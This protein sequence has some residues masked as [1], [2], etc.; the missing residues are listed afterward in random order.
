MM[1]LIKKYWQYVV[2]AVIILGLVQQVNALKQEVRTSV[3][4]VISEDLAKLEASQKDRTDKL[5]DKIDRQYK[6]FNESLQLIDRTLVRITTAKPPT[7]IAGPPGP[8]GPPGMPGGTPAPILVPQP[9]IPGPEV[10]AARTAASERIVV[11]LVVGSLRNCL[12]P[13]LPQ[14]SIELLRQ[15]NG[16][17]LSSTPCVLSIHDEVVLPEVTM[18]RTRLV[19]YNLG[20]SVKYL[21]ASGAI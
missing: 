10:P 9:M 7:V 11:G 17:L 4:V 2:I 14:D 12:T 16:R 13:D 6:T 8:V 5:S 1:D 20:A 18:M 15:S 3:K 21:T 19:T